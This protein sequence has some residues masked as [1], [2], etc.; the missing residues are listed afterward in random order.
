MERE[1]QALRLELDFL[2]ATAWREMRLTRLANATDW[3]CVLKCRLRF[4]VGGDKPVSGSLGL[5]GAAGYPE[6]H[7][8]EG[9]GGQAEEKDHKRREVIAED[10]EVG[11]DARWIHWTIS[12]PCERTCMGRRSNSTGCGPFDSQTVFRLSAPGNMALVRARERSSAGQ[13]DGGSP[14]KSLLTG[15]ERE[16]AQNSGELCCEE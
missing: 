7:D 12:L 11:A 1:S 10:G 9:Q 8:E 16:L 4:E 15:E 13:F 5:G 14:L 3:C 2:T 6:L